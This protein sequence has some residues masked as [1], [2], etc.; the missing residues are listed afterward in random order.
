[1]RPES[2]QEA[3][4]TVY[5]LTQL[6]IKASILTWQIYNQDREINNLHHKAREARYELLT[7]YCRNNNIEYLLTGHHM[8]DQA[9]TVLLRIARGSG[10]DGIAAMKAV[11]IKNDVKIIRPLLEFTRQEIES[12]LKLNG[13]SW[14]NDPSN[15][16]ETYDR[17]RIRKLLRNELE[18]GV[19]TRRL[20]LLA[21]NAARAKEYLMHQ[22][23]IHY[24][25]M[26]DADEFGTITLD[27]N[28]FLLLHEEM[29][30]RIVSY[31]LKAVSGSHYS[32]RLDSLKHV[33]NSIGNAWHNKTINGC[34]IIK[35]SNNQLLFMREHRAIP[36][37]YYSNQS[38]SMIW[39]NRFLV[40]VKNHQTFMLKPMTIKNWH[41][42]KNQFSKPMR[43]Y[44]IRH[45]IPVAFVFH[46]DVEQLIDFSIMLLN[47]CFKSKRCSDAISFYFKQENIAKN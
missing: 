10:I 35:Y 40:S 18:H 7:A 4:Q 41:I 32:P 15:E 37:I 9:E 1:L 2:K 19:S 45:T 12:Y 28:K 33:I 38:N 3:E 11:S 21:N 29:M 34:E 24:N 6:G 47:D 25:E 26:C 20:C 42:I 17:T 5:F 43:H 8:N 13:W 46:N 44:K 14:I 22:T 30:L 31:I 36:K 27:I 23:L 39:D 16:K